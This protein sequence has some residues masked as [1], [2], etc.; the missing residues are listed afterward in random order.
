MEQTQLE[1]PAPFAAI[2][3]QYFSYQ[4]MEQ[5]QLE[6][7]LGAEAILGGPQGKAQT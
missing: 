4:G 5:T 3:I 1:R 6:N 2:G 7:I